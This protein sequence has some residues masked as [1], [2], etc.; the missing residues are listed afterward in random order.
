MK[1]QYMEIPFTD[2]FVLDGFNPRYDFEGEKELIESIKENGILQP[3]TVYK[4]PSMEGKFILLNGERRMRAIHSAESNG[5]KPPKI[6]VIIKKDPADKREAILLSVIANDGKPLLPLEE[7]QAFKRLIE[8]GMELTAIAKKIGKGEGHVKNRLMLLSGSQKV[9]EA[10]KKGKVNVSVATEIVRKA[11][12]DKETEEVLL[13]QA[14]E[15]PEGA[16]Q[17]LGLKAKPNALQEKIKKMKEEKK[18]LEK[19]KKE[20]KAETKEVKSEAKD[21]AKKFEEAKKKKA[22]EAIDEAVKGNNNP[23]IKK[24]VALLEAVLTTNGEPVDKGD[25][26]QFCDGIKKSPV[27]VHM[28]FTDL[29]MYW[30]KQK[31]GAKA[32]DEMLAIFDR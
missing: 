4:D 24:I 15:N 11:K 16:K 14:Q 9:Q 31:Y 28:H 1:D 3:L 17:E 30:M 25:M 19:D 27:E 20:A 2:I 23:A 21:L 13:K 6:P 26:K 18:Q 8:D 22:D 12:G 5:W 32:K 10:L 29:C 7:A